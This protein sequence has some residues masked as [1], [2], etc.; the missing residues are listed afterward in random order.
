[1][2]KSQGMDEAQ[3]LD[4]SMDPSMVSYLEQ[5][6]YPSEDFAPTT[7]DDILGSR[8]TRPTLERRGIEEGNAEGEKTRRVLILIV[9]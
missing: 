7:V 6:L 3:R 8:R 4:T 2:Q 1:M 9:A 5:P